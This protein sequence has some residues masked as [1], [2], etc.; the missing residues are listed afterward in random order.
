MKRQILLLVSLI[1][2]VAAINFAQTKTVT[3]S[4]LEK[5][6][7]K[8]LEAERDYRENYAK[9]GFPSPQELEKQIAEDR[10]RLEEL[11]A[12]LQ[13]ER[14]ERESLDAQNAQIYSLE[15]QNPYLQNQ[16]GNFPRYERNYFYN[17]LPY[18]FY[19]YRPRYRSNYN[20][21]RFQRT[22]RMPPIRPPRP[23]RRNWR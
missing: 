2:S 15:T 11:S 14:L 19:N 1:F 3:N 23:I 10:R 18:G 12:R 6:R 21:R 5:F 7:Q 4:D 9:L 20:R 22:N 13:S 8:R 17:Y 16:N